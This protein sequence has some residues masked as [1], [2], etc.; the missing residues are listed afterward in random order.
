MKVQTLETTTATYTTVIEPD[1]IRIVTKD[2]AVYD[3]ADTNWGLQIRT[4]DGPLKV[5][6]EVSNSIV[7]AR[8][9]W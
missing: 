8:E 6:P 4:P 2:G 1:N 9:E 3:I 7:I 5:M